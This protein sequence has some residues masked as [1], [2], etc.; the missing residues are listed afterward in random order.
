MEGQDTLWTLRFTGAERGWGIFSEGV[1]LV[2]F[3]DP[4]HLIWDTPRR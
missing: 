1:Y 3:W 4:L 2:L